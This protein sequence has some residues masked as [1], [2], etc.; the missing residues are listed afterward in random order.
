MTFSGDAN[1]PS[2]NETETRCKTEANV[3][4]YRENG[5]KPERRL[6][7][8]IFTSYGGGQ[9]THERRAIIEPLALTGITER[10]TS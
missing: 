5:G 8:N 2:V 3:S 6:R 10:I 9:N 4:A 1:L 7:K